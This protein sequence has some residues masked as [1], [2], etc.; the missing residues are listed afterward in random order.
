MTYDNNGSPN[1]GISNAKA[2]FKLIALMNRIN[3]V[4]VN[5]FVCET[6]LNQYSCIDFD[7]I[8]LTFTDYITQGLTWC[9]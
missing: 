6:R 5:Q 2:D 7:Y 8:A 4:E 9:K 1:K 3:T